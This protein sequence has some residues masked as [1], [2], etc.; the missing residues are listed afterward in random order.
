[1]TYLWR[2]TTTWPA[3]ETTFVFLLSL[4]KLTVTI[5]MKLY[6]PAMSLTAMLQTRKLVEIFLRT[7]W[8]THVCLA[9]TLFELAQFIMRADIRRVYECLKNMAL[10]CLCLVYNNSQISNAVF[11]IAWSIHFDSWNKR[12]IV[13]LW[14]MHKSSASL[15]GFKTTDFFI[16][17]SNPFDQIELRLIL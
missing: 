8:A 7:S 11:F 9:L 14:K 5:W 1:M 13:S 10:L 16:L 6:I 2:L 3:V 15:S 17:P 12:K 4:S